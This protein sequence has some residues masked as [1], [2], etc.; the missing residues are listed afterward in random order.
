MVP[1]WGFYN[2][3]SLSNDKLNAVH[4]TQCCT[5]SYAAILFKY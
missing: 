5:L 2:I 3:I 1:N 4:N